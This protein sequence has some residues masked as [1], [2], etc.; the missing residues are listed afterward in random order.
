MIR[1]S[2]LP[3]A[4]GGALASIEAEL[5]AQSAALDRL[6]DVIAREHAA[7]AA[8]LTED[9]ALLAAEKERLAQTLAQRAGQPANSRPGAA[10]PPLLASDA[11]L[12]TL[13]AGEPVRALWR[14]VR[15]KARRVDA[16]NRANG[17]AIAAH[18]GTVQ[19]R[20][21]ALASAADPARTYGPSA[22]ASAIT[23]QS[24]RALGA[25]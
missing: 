19:G 20:I 11:A 22:G 10:R 8:G 18:L 14:E 1:P 4:T 15:E 17:A 12:E 23:P 25:A 6:G 5:R 24:G 16:A 9:I 21:A 3:D 2:S 13:G 7:L